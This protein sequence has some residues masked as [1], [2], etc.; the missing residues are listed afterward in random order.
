MAEVDQMYQDGIDMLVKISETWGGDDIE[1]RMARAVVASSR[2]LLD[3]AYD[4][5]NGSTSEEEHERLSDFVERVFRALVDNN[6]QAVRRMIDLA[7][8]KNDK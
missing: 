2:P 8:L 5:A 1:D 4:I 7:D 3:L 6:V